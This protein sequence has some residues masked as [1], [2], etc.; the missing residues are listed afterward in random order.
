M[1]RSSVFKPDRER[2]KNDGTI[3]HRERFTQKLK[4][5]FNFISCLFPKCYIFFFDKSLVVFIFPTICNMDRSVWFL[6]Y[7]IS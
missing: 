2:K 1:E 4:S 7:S 6:I 5:V 3:E